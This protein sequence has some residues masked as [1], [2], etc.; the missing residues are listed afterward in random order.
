MYDSTMSQGTD[1][2]YIRIA[3]Q[4]RMMRRSWFSLVKIGD[5]KEGF[6]LHHEGPTYSG[7][8]LCSE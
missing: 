1:P 5:P 3:D 8:Y 4:M 6:I 7:D 2:E